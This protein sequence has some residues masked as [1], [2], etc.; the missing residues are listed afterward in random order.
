M[1]NLCRD[2]SSIGHHFW[3]NQDDMLISIEKGCK[4]LS[5]R[6]EHYRVE[7]FRVTTLGLI[8]Y[9]P[10]LF[11]KKKKIHFWTNQG[12]LVIYHI[13]CIAMRTIS[14]L[15]LFPISQMPSWTL[16]AIVYLPTRHQALSK[17]Y[18]VNLVETFPSVTKCTKPSQKS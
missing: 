7:A 8:L 16:L 6:T 1:C 11:N 9:I 2:R 14:K 13:D 15:E 18:I 17:D 10:F 12:L 4:T 3:T 5:T